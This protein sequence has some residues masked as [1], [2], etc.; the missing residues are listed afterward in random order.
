MQNFLHGKLSQGQTLIK[1]F[2]ESVPDDLL[3]SN[4]EIKDVKQTL[5]SLN[6]DQFGDIDTYNHEIALHSE[7]EM[8]K[9]SVNNETGTCDSY[10]FFLML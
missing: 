9:H 10:F 6:L 1:K 8:L 4:P 7:I 3:Q 2:I 5:E